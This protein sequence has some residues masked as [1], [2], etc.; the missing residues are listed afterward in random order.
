[1][2][3]ACSFL[4]APDIPAD[5][6]TGHGGKIYVT[7]VPAGATVICDGSAAGA[8]PVTIKSLAPGNH[9]L[10]ARHPGYHELR[11]TI[12]LQPGQ[13][14][15]VSINLQPVTGLVIIHSSPEGAEVEIDGASKGRTPLLL[16]D[17]KVGEYMVSLK[18]IGYVDKKVD[19]KIED[20]IPKKIS[21]DLT[22][23]SA[24]LILK[25]IPSGAAVAVNGLARGSTPVTVERIPA[26]ETKVEFTLEGCEPYSRTVKLAAG[27][28]QEMNAKLR[29]IPGQIKVVSIPASA[30]IYMNNQF[31]GESPVTITNLAPGDYRL[32]A[33]LTAHKPSARTIT[34]KR[35]E[36][37]VE[38]F[39]L[40]SN[41]GALE[42]VTEP[43]GVKIFIDDRE[44]GET[45]AK[46]DKTDRI[47]ETFKDETV[48]VGKHEVKL[49]KEGFFSKT[50]TITVE[51][52]KTV[53]RHEKLE[54]RF[55][56]DY[57]VTTPSRVYQ[58]VLIQIE[59]TGAVRLEI[60]PGIIKTIPAR[61]IRDRRPI[62]KRETQD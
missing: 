2:L 14:L 19:L 59:P 53:S 28:T 56:P 61:D 4:A 55:I 40:Q 16:T 37:V 9:L 38:E 41:S 58:G 22:S 24:K 1:M 52:D 54:R 21:I 36:Q 18:K 30:R 13:T 20:R 51:K 23:D 26:G 45:K 7:T 25:S 32:R 8:A 42:L 11:R 48:P 34:L 44:I 62:R 47:S 50:F 17:L 35:A 43:A 6:E 31:K 10:I 15:P 12:S 3:A 57:E 49:N 29:E 46:P 33:E 5:R 60:N 39:R 27:E